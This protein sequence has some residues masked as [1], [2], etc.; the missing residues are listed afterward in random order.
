MTKEIKELTVKK[1]S[2]QKKQT[3]KC[4]DVEIIR[5]IKITMMNIIQNHYKCKLLKIRWS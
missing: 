4:A 5:N 2:S 1:R 3:Q